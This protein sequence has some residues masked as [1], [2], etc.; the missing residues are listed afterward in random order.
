MK[1]NRETAGKLTLLAINTRHRA[2]DYDMFS[3]DDEWQ[4]RAGQLDRVA[5][6]LSEAARLLDTALVDEGGA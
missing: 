5:D 3:Q 2:N 4:T 6:L 1:L